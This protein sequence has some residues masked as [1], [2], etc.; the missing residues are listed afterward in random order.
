MSIV[1]KVK[2][3][4]QSLR[5]SI[6]SG[7]AWAAMAGLTQS[8]VTPFALE[9]K[10]TTFQIGLLT[11]VPNITMAL[12]QLF[13]P[14]LTVRIGSRKGMTLMA[15]LIDALMWLPIMLIPFIFKQQAVWF[16][17][18]FFSIR[19]VGGSLGS[20]AWSS[21]M[22]DLVPEGVRGRFFGWRVT[23]V[24]ATILVFSFIA[25]GIME[26]FKKLD[27]FIG[28]SILFGS[29][30]LFRLLSAFLFSR[31]Y[32]P[33][34]PRHQPQEEGLFNTIRHLGG[35]NF[36]RF[37]ILM[38]LVSLTINIA[39]PFYAVYLY[40]D[41]RFDYLP[42]ITVVMSGT[43]FGVI[44]QPFWGR[45]SDRAG[46]VKIM[47][48]AALVLPLCPILWVFSSNVV[49]LV[50]V[51]ALNAFFS[52]GLNL[53]ISNFIL[54]GAKPGDVAKH[55]AIFNAF[56]GV[57][58]FVG[59]LA[60]GILAS[61]LPPIFGYSLRTLFLMTGILLFIVVAAGFRQVKEVRRVPAIGMVNL[62]LGR[63]PASAE[64]VAAK[65]DYGFRIMPEITDE[66][67]AEKKGENSRADGDVE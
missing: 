63:F 64:K 11:S 45:R 38:S 21:M 67:L 18:I 56:S 4:R 54:D 17:I 24:N 36:G 7:A 53:A 6:L 52:A 57:A 20:P 44:F 51:Q 16:L 9:L 37:A 35:S 65:S 47:K 8:Y 13:T 32:E 41:L 10:A 55:M 58:I 29:S 48:M 34:M 59:A 12:S 30:A 60:G 62:L 28:F 1:P 43:V 42:Y 19:V 66:E 61:R 40:R 26:Y 5:L 3:V 31:M 46:N 49:Y 39:G 22:A 14:N 50:A 27:I 23:I 25:M 33:P 2:R 15:M